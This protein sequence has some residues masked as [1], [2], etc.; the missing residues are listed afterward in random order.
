MGQVFGS[1]IE[2]CAPTLHQWK[3]EKKHTARATALET[4]AKSHNDLIQAREGMIDARR[5]ESEKI[6]VQIKQAMKEGDR[7]RARRFLRRKKA[8]DAVI[9]TLENQVAQLDNTNAQMEIISASVA[10]NRQM[11]VS[12]NLLKN[13]GTLSADMVREA[14]DAVDTATD[15]HA[16]FDD[17]SKITFTTP[18]M[19]KMDE[20][21]DD[22]LEAELNAI[23]GIEDEDV[24]DFS[25]IRAAP[26][27]TTSTPVYETTWE[28]T[29]APTS[30]PTETKRVE[31]AFTY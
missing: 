23:A 5:R 17:L 1:A 16:L 20:M 30:R 6:T 25:D 8:N 12:S 18:E 14:E 22:E 7:N 24:S 19:Q 21:E 9:A 26:T 13:T 10:L 3:M 28:Q 2:Q 31:E 27:E 15:M 11:K 4:I 29:T